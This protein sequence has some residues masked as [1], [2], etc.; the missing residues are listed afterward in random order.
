M[1]NFLLRASGILKKIFG[2]GITLCLFSGSLIFI[3]YVS[4]LIIGGE[5]AEAICTYIH[6]TIVPII[7]Y[8]TTSMILIGLASM[9]LANEVALTR[10]K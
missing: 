4:A 3:G 7:V 6:L 5:T 2:Y 9:Y 8:A 10:K 1:K